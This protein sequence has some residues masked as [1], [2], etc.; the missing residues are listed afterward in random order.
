M[1][2]AEHHLIH[3]PDEEGLG[4]LTV[5]R[6]VTIPNA[7]TLLRLL[8]IPLFLWLLFSRNDH[9]TAG[10]TLWA[11]F[12]TDWVDG[13]LA[14]RLG[15]TSNFGKMFDPTVDRLAMVVAIGAIIID[16]TSTP[17]W[18]AWLILV[19]EVALSAFVVA[20]TA[21]GAQRMD[22]T[23]WGKVGAFAN[24]AAFTWFLLSAETSWSETTRQVWRTM[25][26]GAALPGL[27]FSLLATG[28]YVVR[29]RQALAEGRLEHAE[30]A[31]AGADVSGRAH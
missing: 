24:M 9:G 21:A 23:W 1:S 16:G 20:I 4:E 2:G 30:A 15:Q 7:I 31:S 26:W 28:Q 13:Y 8:V 6:I 29:G 12:G 19:R 5:D 3:R 14:R 10:F 17:L 22:V 25:A 18:F 11:L 27:I